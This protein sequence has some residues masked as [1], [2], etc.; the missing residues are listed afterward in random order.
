LEH[1]VKIRAVRIEGAKISVDTPD[2]LEEVRRL[3]K[4]DDIKAEYS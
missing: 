1:G 4:S 2:D 3:M